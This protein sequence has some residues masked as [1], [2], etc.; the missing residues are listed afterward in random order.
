MTSQLPQQR[1]PKEDDLPRSSS[2][3]ED[4][5]LE[6]ATDPN[7]LDEATDGMAAMASPQENYAYFGE[8][9]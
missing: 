9:I 5:A 1:D 2:N 6:N 3:V 8:F 7:Q 4:L